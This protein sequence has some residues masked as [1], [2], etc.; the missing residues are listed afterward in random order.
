MSDSNVRD[1]L[2]EK[3]K[4]LQEIR[5]RVNQMR[6]GENSMSPSRQQSTATTQPSNPASPDLPP[7]GESD[8]PVRS[9]SRAST[10]V[11][12][13]LG[14]SSAKEADRMFAAKPTLTL[15]KPQSAI[16]DIPPSGKT[17]SY[18]K[19]TQTTHTGDIGSDAS[20]FSPGS[21]PSVQ[22]SRQQ[23]ILAPGVAFNNNT[24]GG[25]KEEEKEVIE[26]VEPLT[27]E[28]QEDVVHS[29]GFKDFFMPASFLM[30]R[31]LAEPDVLPPGVGDAHEAVLVR[32]QGEPLVRTQLFNDAQLGKKCTKNFPVTSVE[33][34]SHGSGQHEMF[35]ASY[36]KRQEGQ[37]TIADV[38]GQVLMW[39]VRVP[40]RPFQTFTAPSDV[41]CARYSKF[42]SNLIVGGLYNGQICLWDPRAGSAPVQVTPLTMDAHTHP[43]FGLDVVG[44]VNSHSLVSLSSDGRVCA[45][46]LEK[47]NAPVETHTLQQVVDVGGA[48]VSKEIQA[49]SL[50]FRDNEANKFYLGSENG[51][52]FSAA[53]SSGAAAPEGFQAH[54]SP[55]TSLDCHPSLPGGGDDYSDLVLTSSMDWTCKLWRPTKSNKPL[56]SFNEYTDYVYDVKWSPVHP[57]VF[58]SADGAGCLSVWNLLESMETPIGTV[59][60]ATAGKALCHISWSADG[61]SIVAGDAAGD[62]TLWEVSGSESSPK[63]ADWPLLGQKV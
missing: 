39:S 6:G 21:P 16:V 45:W 63:A 24:K 60:A 43:V 8:S 2:I 13:K 27:R 23:S 9:T 19:D 53:R 47:L 12:Q 55:I 37:T 49:T 35:L 34:C 50:A 33:F 1:E 56:F 22:R 42:K 54:T 59:E 48:S 25:K 51:W 36:Y 28:Q 38:E 15:V 41:S 4:R 5:A 18:P 20:A 26:E 30:E 46:Q 3:R 44:S 57:A 11:L 40:Q 31:A 32:G 58:A 10:S 7:R 17:D 52:L 61:R 62:V 29:G 14:G